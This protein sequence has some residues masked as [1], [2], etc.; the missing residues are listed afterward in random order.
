VNHLIEGRK[1]IGAFWPLLS[2][3]SL[4]VL[5]P[6]TR[7]LRIDQKG[8]AYHDGHSAK[9]LSVDR[10]DLKTTSLLLP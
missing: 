5:D 4:L 3:S 8:A 6:M 2:S 10:K 9:Q 1:E 7:H